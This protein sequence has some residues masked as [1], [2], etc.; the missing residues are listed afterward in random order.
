M[1][2]WQKMN[3]IELYSLLENMKTKDIQVL[4]SM[5]VIYLIKDRNKNKKEIIKD[6]KNVCKKVGV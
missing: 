6:I 3:N 1:A 5:S 2:K 4:L